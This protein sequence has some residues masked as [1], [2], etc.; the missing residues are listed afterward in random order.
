M[1]EKYIPGHEGT[2]G[3]AASA[4]NLRHV[5]A[6]DVQS[7]SGNCVCGSSLGNYLHTEAAPGVPVPGRLRLHTDV[8]LQHRFPALWAVYQRAGGCLEILA[9]VKSQAVELME[10]VEV[11][12]VDATGSTKFVYMYGDVH[13]DE[14]QEAIDF[15]TECLER[16]RPSPSIRWHRVHYPRL[17]DEMR[18]LM[19]DA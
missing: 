12:E 17:T 10:V 16:N 2:Q 11:V 9:R 5:Y 6:R 8:D 7:G 18:E 3:P 13:P 15:I 1:M 19:K 14:R 4:Y